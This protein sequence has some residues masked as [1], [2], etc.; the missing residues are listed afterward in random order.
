MIKTLFKVPKMLMKDQITISNFCV[1]K[2]KIL[3]DFY[4]WLESDDC[5]LI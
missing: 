2:N 5:N 3:N 1:K 4:C